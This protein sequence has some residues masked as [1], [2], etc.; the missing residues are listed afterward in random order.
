M[1]GKL[2]KKI[3]NRKLETEKKVFCEK[4]Q[5]LS[6]MRTPESIHAKVRDVP[7][8][9]SGTGPEGGASRCHKIKLVMKGGRK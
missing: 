4:L 1:G 3:E 2:G 9:F 5:P 6:Q 7:D 8:L